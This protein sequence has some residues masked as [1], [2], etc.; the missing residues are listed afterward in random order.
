[1]RP[2]QFQGNTIV[3]GIRTCVECYLLRYNSVKPVKSQ[4]TFRS[5][6]SPPSSESKNK[7]SKK[8]VWKQAAS[9][10]YVPP[11][12]RLVFNGLHGVIFR[13]MALF[14]TTAVRT[15]NLTSFVLHLFS[16]ASLKMF[17]VCHCSSS[18]RTALTSTRRQI[19][20]GSKRHLHSSISTVVDTDRQCTSVYL[21]GYA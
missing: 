20:A 9:R 6:I 10:R 12:R 3:R 11:K 18:Q 1:V 19:T 15:S 7:P 14:I 5:N 2:P 4:P 8:P 17:S 21:H 16:V 13:K